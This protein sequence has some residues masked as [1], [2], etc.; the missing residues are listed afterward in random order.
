[1]K[2]ILGAGA[3]TLY[4]RANDAKIDALLNSLG[5]IS[6]DNMVNIELARDILKTDY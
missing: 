2:R 1:M 3:V 6:S 4:L 5:I